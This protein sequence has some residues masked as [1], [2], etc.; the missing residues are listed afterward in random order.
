MRADAARNRERILAVAREQVAALGAAVTMGDLA[1]RCGVAV[2]TL[3]R[4]FP[5]KELLV[6][7][8]VEEVVERL[9]LLAEEARDR[10]R[11]GASAWEEL[12]GFWAAL[13]QG[14]QA[15][16]STR[17]A[18]ASLGIRLEDGDVL[19]S[20][21]TAPAVRT[22]RALDELLRAAQGTGE[23]RPDVGL[24]DLFLLLAQAP[25]RDAPRLRERYFELVSDGLR[26]RA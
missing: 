1:E 4:H 7:A 5:T 21:G 3:Y 22:L 18:A 8:V 9:A 16:G 10:V 14:P 25:E 19:A 12:T 24:T 17:L 13:A 2:G 6:A 11:D 23:M 26:P 15:S 20:G